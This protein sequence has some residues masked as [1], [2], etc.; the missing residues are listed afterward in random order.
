MRIPEKVTFTLPSS[1][2]SVMRLST[3]LMQKQS[4]D[5]EVLLET[6]QLNASLPPVS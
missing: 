6:E 2:A 4:D 5:V 3:I 1:D